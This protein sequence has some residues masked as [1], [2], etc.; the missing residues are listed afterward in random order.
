MEHCKH[1]I[2]SWSCEQR[3]KTLIITKELST[4]EKNN[5]KEQQMKIKALQDKLALKYDHLASL[6]EKI[7]AFNLILYLLPS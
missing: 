2:A 5:L 1:D 3:T 7:D 4:F 6:I